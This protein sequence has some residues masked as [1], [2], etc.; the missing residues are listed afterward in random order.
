[1][2]KIQPIEFINYSYLGA[3]IVLL[4]VCYYF[5][6]STK[7]KLH[8]KNLEKDD[9]QRK[10]IKVQTNKGE[11]AM[12]PNVF[13]M[14]MKR[15]KDNIIELNKNF[16]A[17]DCGN[18]K[19][20]LERTKLNTK[21]YI[22]AN[23]V[24]SD[25]CDIKS[26]F[27]MIDDYI[28]QERDLLKNKLASKTESDSAADNSSDKMR[29][30]ILEI[31]IDID[32]I[33]F[34]VRSSLCKK[35]KLD[36]TAIDSLIL[37]L[38]RTNCEDPSTKKLSHD[39][40]NL[41]SDYVSPVMDFVFDGKEGFNGGNGIHVDVTSRTLD[42]SQ[43]MNNGP[44][45]N[46][47]NLLLTEQNERTGKSQRMVIDNKLLVSHEMP[48]EF[49]DNIDKGRMFFTGNTRKLNNGRNTQATLSYNPHVDRTGR[50][51]LM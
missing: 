16:S 48:S 3:A 38:Y 37:E 15:M 23:N 25:F 1:M 18:I 33:L 8:K 12:D 9:I 34:L 13:E 11:I 22:N 4:I 46:Y 50:T 5:L 28:L 10:S 39:L 31:L 43:I 42:G 32:I 35:G 44:T 6:Q 21:S 26:K 27:G 7:E 2:S 41:D 19:K 40:D 14:H 30:S 20:Y 51:S 36:L 47:E 45:V 24:N 17:K 29:Y 49:I